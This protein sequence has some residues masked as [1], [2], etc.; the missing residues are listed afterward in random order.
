MPTSWT[1]TPLLTPLGW[2]AYAARQGR[3]GRLVLGLDTR[4][5]ALELLRRNLDAQPTEGAGIPDLTDRLIAFTEGQPTEFRTI[6][7]DLDG[8]PAFRRRVLDLCAAIP[9]G[10]TISY[11]QLA[12]QAGAP[13]A[14]RAVGHVMA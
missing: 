11:A 9:Y 10:R 12:E 6:P 1:V 8:V 14:A 2:W 3:I 7:V 13:R 4:S 5:A